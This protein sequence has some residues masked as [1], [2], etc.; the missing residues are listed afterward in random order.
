[1]RRAILIAAASFVVLLCALFLFLRSNGDAPVPRVTLL[2]T[3]PGDDGSMGRATV[4][5]MRYSRNYL[6]SDTVSWWLKGTEVTSLPTP[7]R[8]GAADSVEVT[9]PDWGATYLFILTACDEAGN[10]SGWSNVTTATTAPEPI[11]VSLRRMLGL[12]GRRERPPPWIR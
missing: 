2:W 9:L 1:M 6:G 10:C 11:S 12:R 3:A 7:S 8:S 5:T 4:Y